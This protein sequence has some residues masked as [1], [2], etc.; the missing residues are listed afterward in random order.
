[1][2]LTT[3]Y[4]QGAAETSAGYTYADAI[5]NFSA[6]NTVLASIDINESTSCGSIGILA[7]ST[8]LTTEPVFDQRMELVDP[9]S[10]QSQVAADGAASRIVSAVSFDGY[11]GKFVMLSYG[12]QGDTTTAYEAK[13]F[14]AQPAN[15]GP[16]AEQLA[17]EGYFISAFGGNDQSGYAIVGMRVMGD[18]TPRPWQLAYQ[19]PPP[20]TPPSTTGNMP[21]VA[22]PLPLSPVL[23]LDELNT[24]SEYFSEQ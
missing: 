15:V 11:T 17:N 12:W 14:I 18:T 5:Q 9:A 13:T 10:L 21:S 22:N 4:T 2:P 7:L 19:Y 6:P 16:D 3:E 8:S 1:M 20:N 23:W 24:G